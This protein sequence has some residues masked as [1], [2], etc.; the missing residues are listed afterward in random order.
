MKKLNHIRCSILR[1][2]VYNKAC[3]FGSWVTKLNILKRQSMPHTCFPEYVFPPFYST[4]TNKTRWKI[5]PFF[6]FC[7]KNYWLNYYLIFGR[8]SKID[9]SPHDR[10]W[11]LFH[12]FIFPKFKICVFQWQ[13][14]Q[15]GFGEFEKI[16]YSSRVSLSLA[17]VKQHCPSLSRE[18][19]SLWELEEQSS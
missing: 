17:Y 6:F 1:S 7:F 14:M 3:C 9:N 2:R 5:P 10:F 19:R 16:S 15:Y 11:G 13:Q 12:T 8:Q 18:R 4:G